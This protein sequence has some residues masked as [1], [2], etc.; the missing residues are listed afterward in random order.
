[1]VKAVES[2]TLYIKFAIYYYYYVLVEVVAVTSNALLSD[3]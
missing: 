1:M 3:P 2:D